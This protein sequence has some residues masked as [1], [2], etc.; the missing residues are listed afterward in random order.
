M[1]KKASKSAMQPD[2]PMSQTVKGS[3]AIDERIREVSDLS[4]EDSDNERIM[5][6]P[7]QNRQDK[8]R[9]RMA[10]GQPEVGDQPRAEDRE[11]RDQERRRVTLTTDDEIIT[12]QSMETDEVLARVGNTQELM[13]NVNANPDLWSRGI[14][15][16]IINGSNFEREN[17]QLKADYSMSQT[18]LRDIKKQAEKLRASSQL[19]GQDY[20]RAKQDVER[21]RR[22][23][24]RYRQ[25]A[26]TLSNEVSELRAA[27]IELQ[28]ENAALKQ[29]NIEEIVE[30]DS[31][32][33]GPSRLPRGKRDGT[34]TTA[35]G[36]NVIASKERTYTPVTSIEGQSSGQNKKYPDVSMFHGVEDRDEW[37]SWKLH[38]ES[39]F[40][41]SA[42]L[43]TC[44]QDK[45]DYIRDH[46]K[47]T[48]FEVIKTRATLSSDNPYLTASEAIQDLDSMFGEFDKVGKADA[49]LHDP[50][51]PM[52]KTNPKETFDE[53]LARYTSAIAVLG[54]TDVHKISNLRRTI[55][56]KLRW[57]LSDGTTYTSFAQY[58]NRCRQCDLDIRQSDNYSTRTSQPSNKRTQSYND[59]KGKTDNN[60]NKNRK[61]PQH[62]INK[63]VKEGRCFKCLKPGHRASDANAPCK[64][65]P[66]LTDEQVTLQLKAM[67]AEDLEGVAVELPVAKN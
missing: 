61:Y 6:T 58:V 56:D 21:L 55:S 5:Y 57:K 25:E 20:N 10:E 26:E 34:A 35:A 16:I 41:H 7:S 39:K 43:F 27:N 3:Q 22:L 64:N 14:R 67:G 17:V 19:M 11:R 59:G 62:V 9:V 47:A 23:R 12:M 1:D 37:E 44:E 15:N 45:I 65:E 42:T 32:I 8:A 38:L 36:A 31:D 53:F 13:E 54:F 49:K 4:A 63:L 60:T 66:R 28:T 30:E 50:K 29:N 48:A 40:R 33:E 51:F 46:C 52:G 24:D 2:D 18:M